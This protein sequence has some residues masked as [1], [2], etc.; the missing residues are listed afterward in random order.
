MK[1]ESD[2]IKDPIRGL[3]GS[4]IDLQKRLSTPTSRTQDQAFWGTVNTISFL[5][6]LGI[7]VTNLLVDR[8]H[9]SGSV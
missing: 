7:I 3:T 2:V 9:L 8:N 1:E 4:A 5:P 6:I